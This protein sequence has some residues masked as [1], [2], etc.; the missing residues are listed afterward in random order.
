MHYVKYVDKKSSDPRCSNYHV[1]ECNI[2]G[3]QTEYFTRSKEFDKSN[4]KCN[5]CGVIDDIN[6]LDY[7]NNKKSELEGEI[8]KKQEELYAIDSKIQI[9]I[10][11]KESNHGNISNILQGDIK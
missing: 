7:Y 8:K 6:E 9:L 1:Y 2:C 10:L 3:N 11:T 4:R 5:V